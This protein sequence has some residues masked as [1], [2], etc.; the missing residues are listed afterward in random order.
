MNT[1]I[2]MVHKTVDL[3]DKDGTCMNLRNVPKQKAKE[4]L[5]ERS[6]YTLALIGKTIE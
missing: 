2:G 3:L 6:T 5:H 1:I 4:A